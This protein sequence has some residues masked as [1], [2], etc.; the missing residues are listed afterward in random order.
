MKRTLMSLALLLGLTPLFSLPSG[1]PDARAADCDFTLGFQ[2]LRDMIP[3]L[4]GACRE[5]EWHNAFNGDGLQQTTGG[6]L[7]WRKSDNW[8]AFTNGY[9]TWINGP[10]G[11]QMRLNNE[12]FP[13]E[14]TADVPS[15]DAPGGSPAPGGSGGA[16]GSS[17]GGQTGELSEQT[18]NVEPPTVRIRFS[19]SDPYPNEEFN[20]RLE[21]EGDAGIDSMW[22]WATST[23]DDD[24]RDTRVADCRGANPCRHT[25]SVSTTDWGQIV[26]HAKARDSQGQ[27]SDEVT[28]DVIVHE[29]DPTPTAFPTDTPVPTSTPVA[30][31]TATALPTWTA[32]ATLV[33]TSTATPVPTATATPLPTATNT[34]EPTAT[35]L[36]SA[37][38]TPTNTTTVPAVG[39]A[40]SGA[41][42]L[43]LTPA[44]GS[45]LVGALYTVQVTPSA[46]AACAGHSVVLKVLSGP[47]AAQ[48]VLSALIAP[49][50][51][52]TFSYTGTAVGSD[53]F[54]VWLDLTPNGLPDPGEP[55]SLGSV[56]WTSP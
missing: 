36:P 7:V 4:V 27:E 25:W 40:C 12:L 1:V 53:A 10:F 54:E 43:Q 8:T 28:S 51:T 47:H 18:K 46:G 9:Q 50:G 31:A 19:N 14:G 11:L 42:T 17:G 15:P 2:M 41:Q 56:A 20:I 5:N 45:A 37:T 52:A 44:A 49:T 22:W 6:L 21:A 35:P 16:G 24:M 33:P 3:D 30:T 32:T 39:G 13:W 48:A 23:R 55:T 29:P 26:I 38:A 34:A